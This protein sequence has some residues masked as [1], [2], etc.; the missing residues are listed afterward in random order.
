MQQTRQN[1]LKVIALAAFLL[2]VCAMP[3]T[4][5][6]PP[7][8]SCPTGGETVVRGRFVRVYRGGNEIFACLFSDGRRFG[9][10][11]KEGLVAVAGSMVAAYTSDLE[12][13]TIGLSVYDLRRRRL[14]RSSILNPY[15]LVV[16][17]GRGWIAGIELS[18]TVVEGERRPTQVVVADDIGDSDFRVVASSDD[19]DPDSLRI[20]GRTISW[21]EAGT[22]RTFRL[23]TL[24]G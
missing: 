2:A 4:A 10:G 22:R 20:S 7:K 17:A 1:S 19:I 12:V 5:D 8:R 21:L 13:P 6:K 18:Y 3:S 16:T 23:G 24:K 9:L 14:V 15:K 11:E